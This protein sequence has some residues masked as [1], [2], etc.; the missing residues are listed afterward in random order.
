M[1]AI[2]RAGWWFQP[3]WKILVSWDER[4]Y[5]RTSGSW[6][7]GIQRS[8]VKI[9]DFTVMASDFFRIPSSRACSQWNLDFQGIFLLSHVWWHRREEG[10]YLGGDL[11]TSAWRLGAWYPLQPRFSLLRS[12]QPLPWPLWA[13]WSLLSA[14]P[15]EKTNL[16]RPGAHERCKKEV[17]YIL[18]CMTNNKQ[19]MHMEVELTM[20]KNVE[21]CW[22]RIHPQFIMYHFTCC[23]KLTM[24]IHKLKMPT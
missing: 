12:C 5:S 19:K 7:V 9:D 24:N 8:A 10:I 2:W 16:G 17:Q 14:A 4:D 3:S 20:L 21:K 18:L 23:F 15:P 13:C 6:Q 22:K 1:K 11:L